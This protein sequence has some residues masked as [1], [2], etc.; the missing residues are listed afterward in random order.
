MAQCYYLDYQ[1][2]GWFSSANDKYICKL[3][4]KQ[5]DMRIKS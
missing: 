5:F 4:G 2:N 1:S 3:C